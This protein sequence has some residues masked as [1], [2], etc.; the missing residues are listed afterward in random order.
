MMSNLVI[1]FLLV[2]WCM[3]S[4]ATAISTN[5]SCADKCEPEKCAKLVDDCKKTVLDPCQCCNVCVSQVGE[6][7]GNPGQ[8]CD[9]KLQ[10]RQKDPM[11]E[12]G[13]CEEMK[14]PGCMSANCTIAFSPICPSDSFLVQNPPP[15]GE[16]CGQPGKCYCD[17]QKCGPLLPKCENG[18]ELVLKQ[19]G[20]DEPGKCCDIFECKKKDKKCHCP[21]SSRSFDEGEECPAD[22]FRPPEHVTS[23]SCCPI[24]QGCKCRG[25]ICRPAQCA[26]G[27]EV[28]IIK[29]GTGQPGRCCDIF[30]CQKTTEKLKCGNY[31]EGDKWHN[32]SC[33]SCSCKKG[34]VM[35]SK[36]ACSN[37]SPECTWVGIP[38]GECCPIC[39]GCQTD[40]LEKKKRNETWQS[41]D[42]TECVCSKEGAHVCTKHMCKTDCE[43]PRKIQGQCCPVCDEPTIVRP[44]ATCPSLE[45]CSLRCANGLRRDNVGCYVCECLPEDIPIDAQCQEL[46]DENC[47]KQ[48]AHGYL[49]D[50][51]GCLSCKCAKC[52][53]LHQCFKHCLYG[54]ETNSAGCPLCK[55]RAK[56]E[57]ASDNKI[58]AKKGGNSNNEKCI[59]F[60]PDGHQIERDGGEWWS[61]GCRHCFCESR[62]EFCSLIS[63]P[64]KP[65]DCSEEMW[66]QKEGECCASCHSKGKHKNIGSAAVSPRQ[67]KH[68]HTVCQSPGTGRLFTDG[69]TWKL[70]P[71]VSCTCRVGHVLCKT[72]ECPPIPCKNPTRKN[73]DDCCPVC[74][75]LVPPTP[76]NL[77][78]KSNIEPVI[79]EDELGTAHLVGTTWR[80]DDCTSCICKENGE[81][82]CFKESCDEMGCRGNPLVIKGK[83]CPVCS[84]ALSSSAVCSYQSSVYSIGE[85]WQDGYCS[86]CTCVAGGQTV[87][88]QMV[89]PACQNTV[90]IE[91][92]CCPLCKD[93]GWAPYGIGND[94][95]TFL[96]PRISQSSNTGTTTAMSLLTV[97]L[98]SLAVV[99]MLIVLLLVYKKSRKSTKGHK[100]N[101]VGQMSSGGTSTVRLSASKTIGSM[102]RLVDWKDTREKPEDCE[103]LKTSSKTQHIRHDSQNSDDQSDS[104][105]S[106]M[107]DTSTTPSTVSSGNAPISDTQPL[108]PTRKFP[109]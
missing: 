98:M 85:Q 8:V 104:L 16:C 76:P 46:N 17:L 14:S 9:N 77:S 66:I 108:T 27:E 43:N 63:C 37:V 73:A 72:Q 103:L 58:P 48:C 86:N 95:T 106:T 93:A 30:E 52:P 10:C 57:L 20:S 109:V 60:S 21:I 44:P 39:L 68:E 107:S 7:C 56:L 100:F 84:D 2:F 74:P 24:K 18:E 80:K 78:Q 62:Q 19:K 88:R 1:I 79:C 53:P 94:S 71:C 22:S 38:E 54:F 99:G 92:H 90:P 70:A 32:S 65:N 23:D 26:D 45:H 67:Q 34:V 59:S 55:C 31:T 82:E 75:D 5:Q 87:C 96:S 36:M 42:C 61:D 102:P 51:E 69:E 40:S 4:T 35:C 6:S 29:R 47:D 25:L 49:K 97:S 15:P 33:E 91:G 64:S 89:C 12:T 50:N 3:I 83:C 11:N 28:K 13:I 41:D 81:S 101:E 105:L